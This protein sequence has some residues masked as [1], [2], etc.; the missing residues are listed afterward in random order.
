MVPVDLPEP[1]LVVFHE[2]Q[3]PDPLGGLPEIEVRHQQAR[4][5]PVLGRERLAVVLPDDQRLAVQQI[6]HRQVGRIPAIAKRH[7]E[8]EGGS[9]SPAAAKI[10]STVMPRQSVSSFDQ[11]VTQ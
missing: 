8:G 3:A 7:H 10:R 11:R 6:L 9:S 4:R 2:A 5:P 1:W